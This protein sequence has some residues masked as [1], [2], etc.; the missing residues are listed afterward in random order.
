MIFNRIIIVYLM[1]NSLYILDDFVLLLMFIIQICFFVI[2]YYVTTR[3]I[4]HADTVISFILFLF[5]TIL[6]LARPGLGSD[7]PTYRDAYILYKD[8]PNSVDFELGYKFLMQVL[9][10]FNVDAIDY[11]NTV[12]IIYLFLVF[13]FSVTMIPPPYRLLYLS[14]FLF[15]SLSLDFMFNVYR[16]GLSSIIV[17]FSIGFFLRKSRVV[18]LV[19]AILATCFHWSAIIFYTVFVISFFLLCLNSKKSYSLLIVLTFIAFMQP[20]GIVD[21]LFSFIDAMSFESLYVEKIHFYLNSGVASFY[22]L[23]IVGRTYVGL[24]IIFSLVWCRLFYNYIPPFFSSLSLLLAAYGL[25]FLEMSYSFRNYYWLLSLFP[26]LVIMSLSRM[27]SVPKAKNKIIMLVCALAV[28]LS[29]PT[30]Y[31]STIIKQVFLS[32]GSM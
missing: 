6:V 21:A 12:S 32:V 20:L 8:Y 1:V 11:N 5:F 3:N 15:S 26:L 29:I 16:Q 31:T 27:S 25:I 14:L 28:M 30:F 18:A 10:Y 4:R 2:S 17:L 23:N 19:T 9:L 7:E 22:E 24:N 13:L